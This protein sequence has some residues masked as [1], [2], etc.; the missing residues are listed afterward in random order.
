MA[1]FS[2]K[3][4]PVSRELATADAE[5]LAPLWITVL[6]LGWW[7]VAGRA[8]GWWA[9]SGVQHPL[10]PSHNGSH[11]RAG[12][13]PPL[14]LWGHNGR[15]AGGDRRGELAVYVTHTHQGPN[16]LAP[17]ICVGRVCTTANQKADPPLPSSFFLYSFT[18]IL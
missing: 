13:L 5:A 16:P 9:G 4:W 14:R 10:S 6:C 2:P 7:M 15:D 11:W 17:Y 18:V 1:Y 8:A 12:S 3:I